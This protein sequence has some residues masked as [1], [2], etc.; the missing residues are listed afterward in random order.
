M[1]SDGKYAAKMSADLFEIS[2]SKRKAFSCTQNCYEQRTPPTI[3]NSYNRGI[4]FSREK[5]SKQKKSDGKA[6]AYIRNERIVCKVE[7]N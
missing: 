2:I 6:Y 3:E 5:K 4:F 7:D 1:Q